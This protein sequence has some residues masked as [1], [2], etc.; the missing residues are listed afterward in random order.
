MQNNT[1]LVSDAFSKQSA[2]FDQLNEENKLSQYLRNEFRQEVL[3]HLKPHSSI[4]ELNCGTGL[5]AMYF[6]SQGHSVLATDNAPGMLK[7]LDQKLQERHL[8]DRVSTQRC[9]FHDID[10][11][12]HASFDHIISNFGGLNCTGDLR[13][14]L[15]KLAPLLSAHGK[16]T[17]MI[18]PVISPWELLMALKGKFRTA[19]RRLKK[20]APAHI[21]GVHFSCYYYNPGYVINALK[22]EFDVITLKGVCITVPPEFYQGFVERYPKWFARLKKIDAA[23]GDHFPFNRCCDHYL[24]T[25]QKK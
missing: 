1:H 6:A 10:T 9:S 25:L 7:Q 3:R 20:S 11:I 12:R 8:Q 15:S 18:M 22:K 5:D 14:V 24:I 19:F 4:L 23:I 2:V 17:L 21:E 13:D 16:V